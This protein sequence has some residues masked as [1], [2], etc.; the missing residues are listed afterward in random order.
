[1]RHHGGVATTCIHG[2]ASESCLICQ[3]LGT[4][5]T[6]TKEPKLSRREARAQADR[7][8]ANSVPALRAPVPVA[9][10]EPPA[11]G[12]FGLRALGVIFLIVVAFLAFWWILHF[13]L[14]ILHVL[15]I[16]A[17]AA[18]AGYLGYV[19]GVHR[20]RRSATRR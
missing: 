8:A 4:A 15:E 10:Q 9:R 17:A 7:A 2:F 20:G 1:M 12:S 5:A 13:V 6:K 14:G 19:I 11:T 3:T 18:I 16:F